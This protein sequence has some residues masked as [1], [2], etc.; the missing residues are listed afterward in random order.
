V[1]PGEGRGDLND[2]G[3]DP[4]HEQGGEQPRH[5]GEDGNP[6]GKLTTDQPAAAFDD[7][8]LLVSMIVHRPVQ[9]LSPARIEEKPHSTHGDDQ[10]GIVKI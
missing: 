5:G 9:L 2:A 3:R 4:H 6:S 8:P 10:L 7:R 1:G